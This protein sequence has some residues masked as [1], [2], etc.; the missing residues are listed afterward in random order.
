M[1]ET[2]RM[3]ARQLGV[4]MT[5]GASGVSFRLHYGQSANGMFLAL[6]MGAGVTCA[7]ASAERARRVILVTHVLLAR[8]DFGLGYTAQ[9]RQVG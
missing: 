7:I 3:I 8:D 4:N 2:I 6:A 9:W 1:S 5:L